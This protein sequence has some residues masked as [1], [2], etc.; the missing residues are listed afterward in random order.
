MIY[1]KITG[2]WKQKTNEADSTFSNGSVDFCFRHETKS[3]DPFENVESASFVFSG[4]VHPGIRISGRGRQALVLPCFYF[5]TGHCILPAFSKFTGTYKVEPKEGD[6]LY[7]I[8]GDELIK[9]P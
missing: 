7:A 9:K 3:T 8:A 6:L 4:H 5:T 2:T 1:W